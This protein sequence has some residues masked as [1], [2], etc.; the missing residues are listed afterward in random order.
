MVLFLV[1]LVTMILLR[2][3]RKDYA[4]YGKDDDLDDM[5]DWKWFEKDF[6][7][8]LIILGKRF[9]RWIWLETS[10]WRCFSSTSSSDFIRFINRFRLSNCNSNNSLYFNH[11]SI[12]S[13]YGV[14]SFIWYFIFSKKNLLLFIDV[15]YFSVQ[16]YFF[17]QQHRL[18]MVMLEVVY[19]HEWEDNYG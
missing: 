19:M 8:I 16:R 15:H 13:L 9:R 10:S 17:M 7:L 6:W 3:L 1:G 14:N 11:N 18:L 5:V 12:R 2:T 4:R